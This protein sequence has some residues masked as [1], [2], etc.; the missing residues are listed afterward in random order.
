MAL[1]AFSLLY[2]YRCPFAC[3]MHLHVL[4]ARA[5]GLSL[6]V[7]FEPYTLSQGHVPPGGVDVWD[8]PGHDNVLL[9]L[10]VS[11]AVRDQFA[12]S[13]NA[14]HKILFEARHQRGI[15]LTSRT[16]LEPL[17]VEAG[18]EPGAVFAVVDSLGPKRHIAESWRHYHDDLDVFGV[19]TFVFN[20]E[21]A[22]FVRLMDGPDPSDPAASIGVVERLVDLIANR[23]EI[24]ELKHTQVRR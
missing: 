12:E 1:P 8:D 2:D 15:A 14:L 24:N 21:D 11:V 18:L 17:L 19:P 5:A 13:F 3:N 10:E 6:D 4:A 23:T 20:D 22:T 9:A 16:Q 7:T